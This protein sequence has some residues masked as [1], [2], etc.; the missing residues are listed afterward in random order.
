V[1][2]HLFTVT[3]PLL[4]TKLHSLEVR[5][6]FQLA[7]FRTHISATQAQAAWQNVEKDL[8]SG[9]LR[10]VAVN[11]S[12]A[13]RLAAWQARRR[14]AKLGTRSFD[15]LHVACAQILKAN[16]FLSFDARLRNLASAIGL[17]VMPLHQA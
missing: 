5:N 11:W 13:W 8:Q 10:R 15:I 1:K 14:S 3:A 2:A 17:K 4:F 6:A 7:V 9:R 16:E 12:V